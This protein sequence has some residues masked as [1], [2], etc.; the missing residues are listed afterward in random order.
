[1]DVS[2]TAASDITDLLDRQILHALQI[3]PRA[4]FRRIAEVIGTSEQTV[5]RRYRRLQSSGT[6][7]VVGAL[8]PAQVATAW[9]MRLRSR[10]SAASSL[11]DALAAQDNV[12]WVSLVEAGSEVLC[13]L[14]SRSGVAQDDALLQRLPR[15]AEVLGLSA[16]AVLHIFGAGSEDWTGYENL[17]SGDQRSALLAGS[18]SA[19]LP[20]DLERDPSGTSESIRSLVPDAIDAPLLSMLAADG[21]ATLKD[22]ARHC[23]CSEARVARRLSLLR[24]VGWVRLEVEIAT[25]QLGFGTSAYLWLTVGPSE[26]DAA[27]NAMAAHRETAFVSA[28]TGSANLMVSVVCRNPAELYKYVTNKVSTVAG[29]R[30]VEISLTTRRVKHERSHEH[31]RRLRN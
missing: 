28:V 6:I 14:R 5:A 20:A 16:Q 25:A 19:P 9:M 23:D 30:Q 26:L 22:L 7:R 17:L 13:S 8:G 1:M 10:P 27:G 12:A 15:T 18:G 11:A 4:S 3:D 29:V 31:G 21:R 24:R 2:Q